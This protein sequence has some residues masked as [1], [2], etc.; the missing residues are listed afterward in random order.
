MHRTRRA[1]LAGLLVVVAVSLGFALSAVPNVELLSFAVFLAGFL[2]GAK[3]GA[4]VGAVGAA[5]FS[6]FNPLGAGFP[7][8][9]ASQALGQ[10]VV[11]AAGG[12]AGPMVARLAS[13]TVASFLAGGVGL[14]LTVFYDALTTA[15]AYMTFVDEKSITGLVKFAAG[16]LVLAGLHIVWNTVLFF[17]ALVPTLRVLLRFREE[18]DTG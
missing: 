3:Y 17:V 11:G 5:V 13:R 16:G 10:S 4:V 14:V 1:L 2:L 12:L 7:P 6:I 8:L 18:L 15:G 9:V